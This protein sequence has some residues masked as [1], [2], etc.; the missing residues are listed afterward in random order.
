MREVNC[1]YCTSRASKYGK[2]KAGSQRW[3]CSCCGNTFTEK[4]DATAKNLKIFLNWLFGKGV[5]TDMPGNGRT[6]RRKVAKFWTLWPL[7]PKMEKTYDVLYLD[8]IYLSR[9]LC[10]LICSSDEVVLG[11][12]VCRY[13]HSKAW[14]ALMKRIAA[15]RVVISD[16]GSGFTKALRT[17][18]PHTSHQRCLFHVFAQVRRYTTRFPKTL[19]GQELYSLA[20]DLFTVK[21]M[22]AAYVWIDA[23]L[24]WRQRHDSFLQEMTVDEMGNKHSTHERLL[25]A[26]ASLWCL[27]RNNTVFTYLEFVDIT[28]SPYNNRLEGGVN[29]QLRAMLRNHRGLPLERRLKAVYW[30]CYMH[31]H[32]QLSVPELLRCMPTDETIASIYKRLNS[33][34]QVDASIPKWGDAIAWNELHMST[35][36]PTYWD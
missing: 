7:P 2:T 19:A 30:W 5:Q 11:W 26:E 18:W 25:K 13:E 23:L 34:Y 20:K 15:P 8:G 35:E 16:G 12:Y 3:R 17:V 21:D 32:R 36:F 9:K 6:F 22:D 31:S 33:K 14:M 24:A 27:V 4:I 1:P 29:A 10:V 28:V